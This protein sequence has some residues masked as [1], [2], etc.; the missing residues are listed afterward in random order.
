[1]NEVSDDDLRAYM[2][3]DDPFLVEVINEIMDDQLV[4]RIANLEGVDLDPLPEDYVR[5]TSA[6]EAGL[7]ASLALAPSLGADDQKR[8]AR[9]LKNWHGF[10][11]YAT[12]CLQLG[13]GELV[14]RLAQPIP[15]GAAAAAAAKDSQAMEIGLEG[16]LGLGSIG[17]V[18]DHGRLQHSDVFAEATGWYLELTFRADAGTVV[19]VECEGKEVDEVSVHVTGES[20][21]VGFGVQP[22]H[23]YY[24]DQYEETELSGVAEEFAGTPPIPVDVLLEIIAP[25]ILAAIEASGAAF[26]GHAQRG[27]MRAT[28]VPQIGVPFLW[29]K[30]PRPAIG[31]ARAICKLLGAMTALSHVR[32]ELSRLLAKLEPGQVDLAA[33]LLAT[34]S[35]AALRAGDLGA[36]E[37]SYIRARALSD[38]V[39][40]KFPPAQIFCDAVGACLAWRLGDLPAGDLLMSR[41]QSAQGAN[42]ELLDFIQDVKTLRSVFIGY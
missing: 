41:A 35:L 27:G 7:Q 28:A 17:I 2:K 18:I 22:G 13:I 15:M 37:R 11:V 21:V 31:E 16:K 8:L 26:A 23:E 14:S 3:G 39:A 1:M 12:Y 40:L 42:F 25:G 30:D 24:V 9:Y 20:V 29:A 33:W 19:K 6:A 4:E 5:L 32:D 10:V 36:A 34:D 38:K